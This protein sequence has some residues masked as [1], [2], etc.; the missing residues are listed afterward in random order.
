MTYTFS[1]NE[2]NKVLFVVYIPHELRDVWL[3]FLLNHLQMLNRALD[4]LH[5]S[6]NNLKI[7]FSTNK[8]FVLA[9]LFQEI[10]MEKSNYCSL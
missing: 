3:A 9:T 10:Q 1:Q 8:F 4:I 5:F 2:T 6:S 7:A